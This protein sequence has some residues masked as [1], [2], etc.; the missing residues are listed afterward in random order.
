MQN[1]CKNH[2][3]SHKEKDQAFTDASHPCGRLLCLCKH[4]SRSRNN[5]GIVK[6]LLLWSFAYYILFLWL[7]IHFLYFFLNFFLDFRSL[8][9]LIPTPIS[10]SLFLI[11]KIGL[12]ILFDGL[13]W[14]WLSPHFDWSSIFTNISRLLPRYSLSWMLFFLHLCALYFFFAHPPSL[15]HDLYFRFFLLWPLYQLNW[16]FFGWVSYRI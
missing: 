14:T 8:F 3:G 5:F 16:Q 12:S 9:V 11:T 10:F 4:F 15:L 2:C 6:G 7:L 1:T 13:F